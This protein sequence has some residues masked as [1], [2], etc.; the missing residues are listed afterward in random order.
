MSDAD[1]EILTNEA[2]DFALIQLA[3]YDRFAPF[4]FAMMPDGQKVL[5]AA[6]QISD[7]QDPDAQV[8]DLKEMCRKPALSGEYRACLVAYDAAITV[9]ESNMQSNAIVLLLNHVDGTSL[10]VY[11]PYEKEANDISIK[12]NFMIQGDGDIYIQS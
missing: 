8:L 1:L 5:L 10:K 3:K 6:F 4:G 11:V 7:D 9:P 12:P 2:V